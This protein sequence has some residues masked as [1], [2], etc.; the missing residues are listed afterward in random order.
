MTSLSLPDCE[1]EVASLGISS[2]KYLLKNAQ[3]NAPDY[4]FTY[5]FN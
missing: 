4:L 3:L 2:N 5:Y 1:E